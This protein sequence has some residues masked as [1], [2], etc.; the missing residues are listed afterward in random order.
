[1]Y[2]AHLALHGATARPRAGGRP[3]RGDCEEACRRTGLVRTQLV[4]SPTCLPQTSV[5]YAR[6][7]SSLL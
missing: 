1:M 3:V 6:M 7:Q 2:A 5:T 4:V